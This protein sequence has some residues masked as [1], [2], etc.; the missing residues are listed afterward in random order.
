MLY[1]EVR[2]SENRSA[3]PSRA[4]LC[5]VAFFAFRKTVRAA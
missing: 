1:L 2:L 4:A 5:S 3:R